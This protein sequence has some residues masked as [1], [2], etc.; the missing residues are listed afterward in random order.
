MFNPDQSDVDGDGL[1]D[2]CD[3]CD[4]TPPEGPTDQDGD[5]VEDACDNCMKRANM[6]Q[7]NSDDDDTGDVCDIDDDN[8]GKSKSCSF[9]LCNSRTQCV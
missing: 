8:D 7:R 5:K 4:K 9:L 1:G 3:P 6:D 2:V